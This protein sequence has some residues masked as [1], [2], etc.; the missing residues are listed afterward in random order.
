MSGVDPMPKP[1]RLV[2]KD[3]SG[4]PARVFWVFMN[5]MFRSHFSIFKERL[6]LDVFESVWLFYQFVWESGRWSLSEDA[7]T[8]DWNSVSGSF[9]EW[10]EKRSSPSSEHA[11]GFVK[12]VIGSFE[13]F[14][15]VVCS[16]FHSP[17]G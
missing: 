11:S 12:D 16:E 10:L 15:D 14:L 8:I 5:G 6:V 13:F 2:Y 4:D 9:R 3:W 17:S 7:P 1:I